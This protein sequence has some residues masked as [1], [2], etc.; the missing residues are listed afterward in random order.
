MATAYADKILPHK[1]SG[2]GNIKT[3]GDTFP[4]FNIPI[5]Q[6]VPSATAQTYIDAGQ[7]ALVPFSTGGLAIL[8]KSLPL[9]IEDET[10][11]GGHGAIELFTWPAGYTSI[12]KRAAR[13]VVAPGDSGGA[14]LTGGNIVFG[15]GSAAAGVGVDLTGSEVDFVPSTAVNV[16]SGVGTGTVF[17]SSVAEVDNSSGTVKAYLNAARADAVG[18]ADGTLLLTGGMLLQ[19]F[20]MG[21]PTSSTWLTSLFPEFFNIP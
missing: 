12:N 13:I 4:R 8:F 10:T 18:D 15:L 19:G 1:I 14:L 9:L 21:Q 7:L 11:S 17:N 20:I 5:L 16:T 6:P 2:V 3:V